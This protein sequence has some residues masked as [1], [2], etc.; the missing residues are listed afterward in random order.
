MA[1]N[2][3]E[4]TADVTPPAEQA[5][6]PYMIDVRALGD[7]L[8]DHLV[9]QKLVVDRDGVTQ[10]VLLL[11]DGWDTHSIKAVLDEYR[12]NPER[13][14]GTAE[15]QDLDSLIAHVNR[16]KGVN[17]ALFAFRDPAKPTLTG[18]IDYH[19]AGYE[20][21]PRWRKHR[22]HYAFPLSEPWKKWRDM[23]GKPMSQGDFAA[24]LEDRIA[25]VIAPPDFEHAR[26]DGNDPDLKLKT[27]A[28]QLGTNFATPHKLLELSRGLQVN[29]ESAVKNAQN[30]ATGEIAINWQDV[31]K[32]GAG[33]PI[34][35]PGVFLI[36][37]P[38]FESGVAYRIAVRLRYRARDGKITWLFQMY[39][40]DLSF[41]DAFKEAGGR[42][43]AETGLPLFVGTPE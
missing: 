3:P 43:Q 27:L 30:L 31:H 32:D 22:A 19:D 7:Y 35:V 18:V 26:F 21:T 37:I 5:K 1:T 2:T 4:P 10:D 34:R 25:D 17:S 13:R 38:V 23:D 15:L 41:D 24:F 14:L 28:D 16:F 8:K 9:P 39:R 42:A 33:A 40:P 11:P 12:E 29:V 20:G 6:S 36:C